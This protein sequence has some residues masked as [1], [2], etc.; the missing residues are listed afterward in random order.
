MFL[1]KYVHVYYFNYFNVSN[2]KKML[3]KTYKSSE[4]II[5]VVRFEN[6]SV[7]YFMSVYARNTNTCFSIYIIFLFIKLVLMT[8]GYVKP[9][10]TAGHMGCII[11]ISIVYYLS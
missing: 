11:I 6:H 7:E 10:R 5:A 3:L 8:S 9:Y 1:Q 4:K 2:R